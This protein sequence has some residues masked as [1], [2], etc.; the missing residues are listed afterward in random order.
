MDFVN[1]TPLSAGWTVGFQPDGR[2]VLVV[3]AKGTFSLPTS[4]EEAPLASKQ[5]PLVEADTFTE[6]PGFSAPL[7]E[8]DFAHRKP[9]CDVL[10]NGSAWAP[11]GKPTQVVPVS[12]SLGGMTKA[13]AVHGPRVWRK[14]L[15]GAPRPSETKPF[16]SLPISYNNAFG[17][18]D[19]SPDDPSKHRAFPLNPVGRGFRHHLEGVDGVLMPNTEEIRTPVTSPRGPYRP[20]AFGAMGRN[21]QPR[22]AFAGTY[23]ESWLSEGLPFFPKDFDDRY[24]Q[25]A[26][27][28]Q[29]V[30]YPRGGEAVTLINLTRNGTLRFRLPERRV[31]VA[32]IPHQGPTKQLDAALD[33]VLVEP[34]AGHL[35]LTWR[36]AWPLRRDAF[37]M[38]QVVVGGRSRGW[39]RAHAV[40]KAYY[41]NIDALIR[42]RRVGRHG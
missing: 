31:P 3:V 20:M 4:E 12:F 34:D 2:E 1:E 35:L 28:D 19:T 36:I 9:R 8:A 27:I 22:A 42:A 21:W 11:G 38:K 13:F 33:T 10:L 16:I 18:I 40:G 30:P 32:L 26:P 6:E 24:F 7:H 29:Q 15:M 37:E 17:G 14:S 5:L 25:S 41:P 23:D 39:L